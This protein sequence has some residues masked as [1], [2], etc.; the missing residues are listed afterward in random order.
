MTTVAF[1]GLGRMGSAM[2]TNIAKSFSVVIYNRTRQ[3]ADD[4][5]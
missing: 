2:V 5:C 4:L 1:L 3:R